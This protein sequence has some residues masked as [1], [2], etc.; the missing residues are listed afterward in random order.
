MNIDLGLSSGTLW[1]TTNVGAFNPEDNGYYFAWGETEPKE[2]Y[3]RL[4][5]RTFCFD[6]DHAHGKLT[7]LDL[8]ND[9][10]SACLGGQWTMPTSEQHKELI[11]EC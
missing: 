10:A 5:Y 8:P 4:K 2:D 7:T 11:K 1:A 3:I 9:A 6:D